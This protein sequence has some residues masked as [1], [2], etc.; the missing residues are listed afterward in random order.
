MLHQFSNFGE[1]NKVE[2]RNPIS[3]GFFGVLQHFLGILIDVL[4]TKPRLNA[5]ELLAGFG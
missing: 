3:F 5:F 1:F 2:L 4:I